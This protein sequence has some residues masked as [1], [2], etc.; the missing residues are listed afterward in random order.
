MFLLVLSSKSIVFYQMSQNLV[1][2][3]EANI[4]KCG[5]YCRLKT[6][7]TPLNSSRRFFGCKTSKEN[8]GCEYFRWIDPS[9]EKC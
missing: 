5:D 3:E 7:S 8:G 4:C 1:N 6:L 9:P 2:T